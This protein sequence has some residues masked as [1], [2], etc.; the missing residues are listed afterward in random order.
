MK[1]LAPQ[2]EELAPPLLQAAVVIGC[3]LA[4]LGGLKGEAG[5]PAACVAK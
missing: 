3:A 2:V 4:P 1:E 5:V